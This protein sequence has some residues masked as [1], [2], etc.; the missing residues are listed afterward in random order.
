MMNCH[1]KSAHLFCFPSACQ[2]R[3]PGTSTWHWEA[4]ANLERKSG[5]F[6]FGETF[7]PPYFLPSY[8]LHW[9]LVTNFQCRHGKDMMNCHAKSAHLFCFPSACQMRLPGTSTWHWEAVA[10]LERKS[11][12]FV[13]GETF[14]PP[15]FLPSYCLH[16]FLVTNFRC[17]HGKEM[18][19]RQAK[20]AY[21]YCFPSD[22]QMRLPG[23][24]SH[25]FP[26]LYRASWHLVGPRLR[27]ME[28][29]KGLWTQ[30]PSV[31]VL[32]T[33][34]EESLTPTFE[35]VMQM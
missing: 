33:P 9:F 30:C 32:L 21:H 13:F 6:V 18:M 16:W 23:T 26:S 19:Y 31:S 17:R 14:G 8:C 11:G 22:C 28:Y 4:V 7:G 20:S 25:A 24:A 1:A 35:T 5:L 10:N 27:P 29:P 15:Y 12:L 2:M 34:E 3:L